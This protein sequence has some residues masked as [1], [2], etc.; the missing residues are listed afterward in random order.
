MKALSL[1]QPFAE[2]ILQGRKRI[3][4][5][6]WNTKFRGE[7]LIHASKVPDK[8][9]MDRFG[10][11]ELPTGCIVGKAT[12]IEVKKYKNE[13]EH[14]EDKKLHLA[15]NYW[16]N[17]GFILEN[18]KRMKAIPYKGKLNFWE[19]INENRI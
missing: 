4:L 17:Y 6:R 13:E 19:Y 2:L 14:R 12:L 16:G 7:F 9:A 8:K 15:D 3:E 5:R 1:K 11:K 10:F 18:V